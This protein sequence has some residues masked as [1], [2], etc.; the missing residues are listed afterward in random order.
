MRFSALMTRLFYA[1]LPVSGYD[2]APQTAGERT[3][4]LQQLSAM[5]GTVVTQNAPREIHRIRRR[6]GALPGHRAGHFAHPSIM[7]RA[8]VRD[9]G[10]NSIRVTGFTGAPPDLMATWMDQFRL[11]DELAGRPVT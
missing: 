3:A 10:G 1:G 2:F 8:L 11:Q 4:M 9:A 5:P 6:T 7:R